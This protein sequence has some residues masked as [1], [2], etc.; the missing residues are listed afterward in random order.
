[1]KVREFLKHIDNVQDVIDVSGGADVAK[2]LASVLLMFKDHNDKSVA[3]FFKKLENLEF[4]EPHKGV[5]LSVL[6]PA[7]NSISV[8]LNGCASAAVKKDFALFHHFLESYKSYPIVSVVKVSQYAF[9]KPKLKTTKRN[10]TLK[11]IDI[12]EIIELLRKSIGDHDKFMETYSHLKL[13]DL[14]VDDV[15]AIAKNIDPSVSTKSSKKNAISK[16]KKRHDE[17]VRYNKT[18]KSMSGRS[19]A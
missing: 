13:E 9:D 5:S 6:L 8:L 11:P 14:A 10:K 18:S 12:A 1:M 3:A 19:A 4:S 7:I 2:H 15:I 16:I 17:L